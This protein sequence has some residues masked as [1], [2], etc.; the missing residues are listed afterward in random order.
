M[1]QAD[2][3]TYL[4]LH[5]IRSVH[6]VGSIFRTADACDINKIY[7]IGLTPTPTDKFDRERKDLSKVALGAEKNIPWEK[8][9]STP[10]LIKKLKKEG[11]LI[12][13]LEQSPKSVDYKKIK[14]K[15]KTAF[16]LGNEVE[17]ISESI[18]KMSDVV[19]EIPMRGKKESLNVSVAAGVMLFRVLGI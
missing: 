8:C 5:N 10:Q 1:T 12:V 3:Q 19:A 11:F 2:K 17:G 13:S 14:I 16:I 15:Q 7:L 18:L 6:N 9:P 4:I